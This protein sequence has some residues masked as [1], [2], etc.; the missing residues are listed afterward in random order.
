MLSVHKDETAG[1]LDLIHTY[2][3]LKPGSS[4]VG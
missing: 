2:Y 1:F 4:L 3:G